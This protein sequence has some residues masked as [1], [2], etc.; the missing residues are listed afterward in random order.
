MRKPELYGRG[1]VRVNGQLAIVEYVRAT[2]GAEFRRVDKG[3]WQAT[4]IDAAVRLSKCL[5]AYR[6]PN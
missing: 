1:T 2:D 4:K 5:V 3:A 6:L